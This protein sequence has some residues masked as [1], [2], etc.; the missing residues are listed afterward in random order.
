M[1]TYARLRELL[2]Y[3][4][5]TGEFRWRVRTNRSRAQIGALAGS[6]HKGQRLDIRLDRR[7]YR[8]ARLAWL[9][10]TSAWPENQVDH[11]DRNPFNNR[12]CNLREATPQENCRNRGR[13]HDNTSGVTGVRWHARKRRWRATIYG[14][15]G[16]KETHLGY[17]I[18]LKD[19][20]IARRKAEH[21]HYGEFAAA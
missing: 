13:R 5:L 2:D 21:E 4:P 9:F 7:E 18:S 17:F 19:A 15:D 11:I 3:D 12:W 6:A 14:V 10:M 16:R 8:A 1:L 20:A